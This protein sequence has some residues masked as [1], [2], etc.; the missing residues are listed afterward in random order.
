MKI[1]IG[2]FAFLGLTLLAIVLPLTF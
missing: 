1:W 2:I